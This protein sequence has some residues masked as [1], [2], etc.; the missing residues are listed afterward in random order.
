MHAEDLQCLS[1]ARP[2]L[3]RRKVLPTSV[4]ASG[5]D[6]GARSPSRPLGV[7]GA[8]AAWFPPPPDN[9][10]AMFLRDS[11]G[12]FVRQKDEKD[13]RRGSGGQTAALD[14]LEG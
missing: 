6:S 12:V 9:L 8:T 13:P 4:L 1:A 11:N 14:W 3:C 2:T 7:I 10:E 5:G